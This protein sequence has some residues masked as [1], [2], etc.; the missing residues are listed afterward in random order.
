MLPHAAVLDATLV[1]CYGVD[2]G[3]HAHDHSQVLFG[4]DGSLELEV[5]G[6]A[7]FVDAA[8]GLVVPAGSI[9]TY[10]AVRGARVL[11]LDC[12]EGPGTDRFRRFALP[13]GWRAL[14]RD[15]LLEGLGA[16]RTLQPRRRIDLAALAECIDAAPARPWTV[17]E[18]AD[19][20]HLSSQRF[21]ARFAELTGLSPM[22]FVRMRR[23]AQAERLLRHGWSLEAVALQVGYASASALSFAL[24][25]DRDTG[26]RALRGA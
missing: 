10:Q 3:C 2:P 7:A 22:A 16:A 26:A 15:A 13:A 25:R 17:A 9:H 11:V 5:E 4:V 12:A 6:H 18:L 23:L 21:R 19:A 14:G 24:R 20:C 1:R 8:S